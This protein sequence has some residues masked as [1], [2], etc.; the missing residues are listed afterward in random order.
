MTVK[1]AK[2]FRKTLQYYRI[3]FKLDAPYNVLVDGNLLHGAMGKN[4]DLQERL[5]KLLGTPKVRVMVTHCAC[6]EL[7]SMGPACE[8]SA[9]RATTMMRQKCG[10][11][12]P[13]GAG[14]C[15]ETLVGATNRHR[16]VVATQDISL[17]K[18]LRRIPGVPLI[19]LNRTN[20][21]LEPPSR[22]THVA[23]AGGC[24]PGARVRERGVLSQQVRGPVLR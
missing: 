12:D 16:Y 5:E 7:K 19:Y 23:C 15:I 2:Q 3:A 22:D 4:L 18:R 11:S 9:L 21:V 14:E 10:H 13:V 17:R 8:E 1:K 24:W 6:T 20:L